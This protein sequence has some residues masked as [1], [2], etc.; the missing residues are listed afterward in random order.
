MWH[1]LQLDDGK[2]DDWQPIDYTTSRCQPRAA[3]QTMSFPTCNSL[4]EVSLHAIAA[5]T[6]PTDSEDLQL[7]GQG[8]FRSTW[9]L[10][11]TVAADQQEESVVLKTLR[12]EREYKREYYELHR[13]DAV[14]MERLTR[15]PFVVN[16]YGMCGNSALNELADFPF[17]GVQSLEVFNRRMRGQDS[18]E[19]QKIKLRMAASIAVGLA[20]VHSV[21]DSEVPTLAHYDLNPRN[22]AL[23]RGGRPKLNDF[24]IAEFLH[25]DPATNET[26]GF[27]SRLHEPWWRA[28]EE[29]YRTDPPRKINEKV[30]V[31]ALGNLLFHTLTTHSPRGKMVPSRVDETRSIVSQGI[32]PAIYMPYANATDPTSVAIRKAMELC[33]IKDPEKRASAQDISDILMDALLNVTMDAESDSDLPPPEADQEEDEDSSGGDAVEDKG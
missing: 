12:L 14:A 16:V 29:M 7:L 22:V 18:P 4:H 11:R 9:R 20:D 25:Y 24:N 21:D 3:W 13:R 33:F 31:Y 19:V 10:D 17:A 1:S 8:W 32:P 23:F 26:C 27:P 5:A 28:P 15:S 30:D 6:A 2:D